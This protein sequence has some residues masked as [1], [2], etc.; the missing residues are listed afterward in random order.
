M[1][2]TQTEAEGCAVK[3]Y[4]LRAGRMSAAQRRSYDALYPRWA[5]KGG[6]SLA[7]IDFTALFGN[8]NP[9]ILEIGFGMG[10]AT[11]V[12][13]EQNPATNYLG[14]EVHRPGIGRLLWEIDQRGLTNIRIAEGD[15]VEILRSLVP[16]NSLAG[17]HVFFPDPWPK[18]RHHKRRLIT[19]PFT[20]LLAQKLRLPAP[21]LPGGYVYMVTDW[22]DYAAWALRELSQ[23]PELQNA[24]SGY[25]EPQS[26][27][28]ETTFE[29]KGK[30]KNHGLWEMYFR[31]RV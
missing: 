23:T 1:P 31:R 26:W 11:A 10:A 18:K 12:I 19:L 9:V 14:V 17:I 24:Y 25:A 15:A 7:P 22:E 29:R 27:R 4:V 8:R 13:A 3:S 28:P 5:F 21:P 30:E 16:D 20:S 6:V 2:V